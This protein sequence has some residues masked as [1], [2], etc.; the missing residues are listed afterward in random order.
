MKLYKMQVG[1][2]ETKGIKNE[3]T[4]TYNQVGDDREA[5][6]GTQRRVLVLGVLVIITLLLIKFE[7]NMFMAWL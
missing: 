2:F 6:H 3:Y 5:D 7:H 4:T 1:G